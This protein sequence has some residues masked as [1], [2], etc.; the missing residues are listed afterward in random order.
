MAHITIEAIDKEIDD[1]LEHGC[2]SRTSL[3]LLNDLC[4]ARKYLEKLF[5]NFEEEEAREWVAKMTPTAKWTMEQTTAVMRSKGYDHNP[6]EFWVVMNMLCSDYGKTL[7]KYNADKPEVWADMADAW[8][9]D[10]DVRPNKTGRYY[11]DIV[12][13]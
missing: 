9:T 4:K 5:C 10:P 11:R 7:A 1:L 12:S 6:C 13:H 3:C 2:L 8:I